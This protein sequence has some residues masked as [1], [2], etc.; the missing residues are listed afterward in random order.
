MA[1]GSKV[2]IRFKAPEHHQLV[3]NDK[4]TVQGGGT[5]DVTKEVAE[6]LT[7]APYLDVELVEGELPQPDE[8]ELLMGKERDELNELAEQEGVISPGLLKNKGEVAD[9]ILEQ[10]KQRDAQ[11]DAEADAGE[12]ANDETEVS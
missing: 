7:T 9:A 5:A 3:I 12:G 2:T 11:P 4:L 1:K 8:R 10:R 6:E